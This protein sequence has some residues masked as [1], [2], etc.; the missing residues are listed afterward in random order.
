M[1]VSVNTG[2]LDGFGELTIV[3]RERGTTTM[4]EPEGEWDLAS[5][6][7]AR[8]TITRVL[9]AR[10]ECVVLDLSRLEF[11]DSSGLHAIVELSKCAAAQNTRLVIIP[12]PRAVQRLF[13]ITGLAARLPLIDGPSDAS[14]GSPG[15]RGRP[16]SAR[17][18]TRG[19]GGRG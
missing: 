10:P 17:P 6:A 19:I 4:I 7:A 12:G 8:E 13:E 1:T 11:I 16:P 5:V 14:P 9:D 15:A 2:S 18:G 3:V